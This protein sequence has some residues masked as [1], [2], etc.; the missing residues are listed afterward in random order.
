MLTEYFSVFFNELHCK[1][2]F[3]YYIDGFTLWVKYV[4]IMT[5]NILVITETGQITL[6]ARP[7][8]MVTPG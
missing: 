3:Y 7:D 6:P 2:K 1:S 5:N 4:D 8:T